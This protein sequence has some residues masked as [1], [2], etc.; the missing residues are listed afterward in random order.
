MNKIDEITKTDITQSELYKKILGE[1]NIFNAIF[2]MESYIFDKGLLDTEQPVEVPGESDS[3]PEVIANNDLELYYALMD[4]HNIVLI[5]KVIKACQSKLEKI[6]SNKEEL[7]EIKVYFKLKNYDDNMLSFRPL[8][9]ARLIDLICMVSTL[10]CLM[11]EDDEEE[12]KRYLSD[13]SKL[14]PHNFYGNIPSTDV[15]YLF[16]KWQTKY[17]EYT[18][19]VV[20][21]CREYQKNHNYLT[22]VCLDIK[23]FFPSISPKMLYDFIV[24]KLT[25]TFCSEE[26]GKEEEDERIERELSTLKTAVTKLLFFK[27]NNDNIEPWKNYY[28]TDNIKSSNN[29]L[30]MSCGVPQ[31]LPQS[32]YFGNLCMTEIK[33]ILME[34][35]CFKGDAYFY[36]DDSVIY[37]QKELDDDSFK[38]R[39]LT[40]NKK[41]SEWCSKIKTDTSDIGE[42]A[43]QSHLN[44][45]KKLEYKIEF[46]EDG[47]SVF[48]HIDSTDGRYGP[49]SNLQRE[50]SMSSQVFRSLDEIDDQ[51]SL[52]KLEALNNVVSNEIKKLKEEEKEGGSSYTNKVSS[53][54]KLLRR[55]KKFFL[56]RLRLLKIRDKGGPTDD[57]VEDFKKRFLQEELD[58]NDWLEQN[59]EEIFQAEYQLLIQKLSKEK[60]RKLCK[61]IENFET[62]I[63]NLERKEKKKDSE[64]KYLFFTKDASTAYLMKSLPQDRYR[65]LILLAKENFAGL[66]EINSE[67]QM[68]K[69]RDF[70][71][72]CPANT[73]QQRDKSQITIYDM[74]N[75]GY[76]EKEFTIFVMRASP[77]YQRRI[78]NVYFSE[79][80]GVIPSDNLTFIKSNSHKF[81]Y[82]ELR[83]LAY[84]RNKNFDLDKFKEFVCHINDKDVS[85]RMGIDMG[86]LNVLSRFIQ[87]VRNPEWVDSLILTHRLTKGLW[88]NGSKFLN[89]YTLHNEE[90]A[91]T[92]INK[93]LEL[94][95]RIDYFVLKKVDY[96]ILFLACYLHDISMV[97]HPNL[98]D[99]SSAESESVALI[100]NLMLRMK[101]EVE[102]FCEI[103]SEDDKNSRLKQAGNFL[104]LVFKKVYEY[105]ESEI[106]DN[107]AMDSARFIRKKSNTLLSH[108]EPTLVS[109]VAKVSESHG[110]DVYDVYGLKSRAKDDTVSVKYLMML[111]RLA[112]LLDVSND[113][114]NYHLLQQNLE[115]LSLTSQFHWISHLVTDKIE[116]VTEYSSD[117]NKSADEKPILEKIYFNLYLN[118]KQLT[119]AEKDIK[120]ENRQCSIHKNYLKIEIINSNKPQP[121]CN[122]ENCTVLCQW[123]MKKH[124]WLIQELVALNDYLSSV[125]NSLIE[126]KI[127]FNIYYRN[128]ETLNPDMFD[129]V[130]EYLNGNK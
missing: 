118:V 32:Y 27:L 49:L 44:F 15:Q 119:K 105:F 88:Y 28:Y 10:T 2:C 129:H 11:F 81:R 33:K 39:I 121:T 104:I 109:L 31:G 82:T 122:Q 106:R 53:R 19:D 5:E 62:N 36:V 59:E 90:H 110:Y 30:Y 127:Y 57:L 29:G 12:G 71:D 6:F 84:L 85:N 35:N 1:Q 73:N 117:K 52:K 50:V 86:L 89:S 66:K 26:M 77:E 98:G 102:D 13:L 93:S 47:K 113:R 72:K 60:A 45:H 76:M 68:R 92:L 95:N 25:P 38:T 42:Y 116:L 108:L 41:L 21:H 83:I 130:Q 78:L 125:N 114:V 43:D 16:H 3:A 75:N 7:F 22:E 58:L 61:D 128:D 111:I 103:K 48:T 14:I 79:I 24:E 87:Y 96:Y 63:I 37:V 74:K 123:M 69:F 51:V 8:H 64:L 70:L 101:D 17:K 100:S 34:E 126:T 54:L 40:L 56:F 91:V 120:C 18:V 20:E 112:D 124:E 94:I 46:H 107:H 115:H 55:Y 23:N 97:I 4:K 99:L 80:I 65:S 9:T 67:N